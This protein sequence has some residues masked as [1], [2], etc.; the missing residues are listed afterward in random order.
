MCGPY[1]IDLKY[2]VTIMQKIV[3]VNEAAQRDARDENAICPVNAIPVSNEESQTLSWNSYD[4][5]LSNYISVRVDKYLD[6]ARY[7]LTRL[8]YDID[9]RLCVAR[10]IRTV[11]VVIIIQNVRFS[12]EIHFLVFR[13]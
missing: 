6:N 10:F 5:D 9:L 12:H 8:F 2:L 11:S 4:L 3:L 1:L 13:K 7:L